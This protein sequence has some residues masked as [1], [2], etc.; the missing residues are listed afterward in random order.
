MVFG[1][2]YVYI[3]ISLISIAEA[4]T[5]SC[6]NTNSTPQQIVVTWEHS[7][8]FGAYQAFPVSLRL[9]W[10]L[11]MVETCRI[12]EQLPG[13]VIVCHSKSAFKDHPGDQR[14]DLD[15]SPGGIRFNGY[16]FQSNSFHQFRVTAQYEGASSVW[17]SESVRWRAGLSDPQIIKS[18]IVQ[19]I[20]YIYKLTLQTFVL[21]EHGYAQPS[22]RHSHG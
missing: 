13:W 19:H 16:T 11:E 8:N 4:D 2:I 6:S 15:R 21:T 12:S 3:Y 1:H 14:K 9:A 20:I 18:K 7:E 17:R 10:K 22:F 5:S